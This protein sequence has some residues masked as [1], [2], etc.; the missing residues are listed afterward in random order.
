MAPPTQ[1]YYTGDLYGELTLLEDAPVKTSRAA[2]LPGLTVCAIASMAAAFLS[3]TYGAPLILM[4]LLL[5]LA[6]SFVSQDQRTHSGLDFASRTILRGGIILLGLQVTLMQIAEL[7]AAPFAALIVVMAAAFAGGL[8]FAKLAG[9]T[10]EGGLLAGGA[11]AICGAS[12]ALA[13]Y[14]VIGRER[15]SQAQFAVTLVGISLASAAALSIYPVLAGWLDLTDTQAGFLTG[16]S[17]HDV[18]QAIGGGYAVSDAAG[19]YATV[20]KL[21]RVA[22]LA[23]LVALAALIIRRRTNAENQNGNRPRIALPGFIIMFLA[24]LV[25]NSFVSMPAQ[26][27]EFGLIASKT[28]LLLAVT[29][30]AM[31]SRLDL[32]MKSGWRTIVP[33]FGATFASL[34]AALAL[35]PF[36]A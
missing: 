20:V 1:S 26:V 14:G 33:V 23:P 30:T 8:L 36:L 13:L 10:F 3:Q 4:G 32:L 2:L 17:I 9:Q 21:A 7:G 16:A 34:L 31:R 11:T 25:L 12:A 28:M 15:V 24:V 29:A 35:L 22:L 18:A 6:L 27:G 19:A 5:G